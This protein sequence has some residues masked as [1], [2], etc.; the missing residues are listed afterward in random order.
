MCACARVCTCV[1]VCV[2]IDLPG[3]ADSFIYYIWLFRIAYQVHINIII[4]GI[5]VY[6]PIV[7]VFVSRVISSNRDANQVLLGLSAAAAA[8][9]L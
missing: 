7:L 6:S 3:H 9:A 4:F 1:G 8:A 2:Y 5:H